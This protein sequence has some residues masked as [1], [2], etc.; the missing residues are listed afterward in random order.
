M[1]KISLTILFSI[2]FIISIF[3]QSATQVSVTEF[4]KSGGS[5]NFWGQIRYNTVVKTVD[6]QNGVTVTTVVCQGPGNEK[7]SK[8]LETSTPTVQLPNNNTISQ[9]VFDIIVDD[10][11]DEIEIE[12]SNGSENGDFSRTFVLQSDQANTVYLQFTTSWTNGNTDGD[13]NI[14]INYYDVTVLM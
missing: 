6:I 1:K 9:E 3:S 7:C 14:T 5:R 8:R 2:V 12:L 13:G 10:L 11:I 4:Y